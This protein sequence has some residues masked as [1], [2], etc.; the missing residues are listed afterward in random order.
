MLLYLQCWFFSE[1]HTQPAVGSMCRSELLY[2]PLKRKISWLQACHHLLWKTS[3]L[4]D[5][6]QAWV[7]RVYFNENATNSSKLLVLLLDEYTITKLQ[8]FTHNYILLQ[9]RCNVFNINLFSSKIC[10]GYCLTTF[11]FIQE[12]DQIRINNFTAVWFFL[13][14]VIILNCFSLIV[15]LTFTTRVLNV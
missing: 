3:I 1:F 11:I 14:C 4:S 9:S 12:K 2:R 8:Y 15:H 10:I 6:L 13:H 5:L 7:W